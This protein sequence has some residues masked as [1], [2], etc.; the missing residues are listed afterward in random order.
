ME[1]GEDTG[2]AFEAIKACDCR[3]DATY[4][5]VRRRGC[6]NSDAKVGDIAVWM[7]EWERKRYRIVEVDRSGASAG[8]DAVGSGEDDKVRLPFADTIGDFQAG[9]VHVQGASLP[10]IFSWDEGEVEGGEEK[11]RKGKRST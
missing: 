7:G 8:S 3:S 10:L 6:L 5:V 9:F 4:K 2:F 1:E 11:G